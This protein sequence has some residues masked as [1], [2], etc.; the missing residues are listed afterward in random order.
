LLVSRRAIADIVRSATLGSYGVAGLAASPI[1]R[2]LARI[3]LAS[4]GI[5]VQD[6]AG[7]LAIE[8]DLIVSHGLPIAEVARQV[9]AAIRHAVRRGLEREIGSVAIH[10]EH[11]SFRSSDS[12]AATGPQQ[13]SGSAAE[14]GRQRTSGG[15]GDRPAGLPD[16]S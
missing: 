1:S 2:L 9:D 12:T 14:E 5:R 16:G 10:V 3:G 7:T 8:L 6:R 13:A 15:A 4:P 11:L